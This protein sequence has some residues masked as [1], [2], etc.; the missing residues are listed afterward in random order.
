MFHWFADHFG[1][2]DNDWV[3]EYV[4]DIILDGFKEQEFWQTKAV[5]IKVRMEEAAK[6]RVV[7]W[8]TQSA[9]SIFPS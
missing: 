5:M 1:Y 2:Y 7:G 3:D 8:R 6:V 9:S 4:K